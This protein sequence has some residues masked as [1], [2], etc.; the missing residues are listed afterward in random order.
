M[1][2][3]PW[4]VCAS[5]KLRSTELHNSPLQS[6]SP[7]FGGGEGE[8]KDSRMMQ[9]SCSLVSKKES[10]Q[11]A[12]ALYF[13]SDTPH[14]ASRLAGPW[15]VGNSGGKRRWRESKVPGLLCVTG[16]TVH[17]NTHTG[18]EY[19]ARPMGMIRSWGHELCTE[20]GFQSYLLG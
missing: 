8:D 3:A 2:N 5:P 16:Q 15:R 14:V 4:S 10:E 20:C 12:I 17:E 18:T 11:E 19:E 9:K 1:R 13:P 6:G 7:F